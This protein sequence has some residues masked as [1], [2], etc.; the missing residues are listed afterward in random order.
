MSPRPK[1]LFAMSPEHLP[2][3][4]PEPLLDRLTGLVD[5]D[6]RLVGTSFSAEAGAAALAEAEILVTSW[7][8]PPL[9]EGILRGA[10]RL[11]SVVHAAGSVKHLVTAA[12][13]AKGLTFSS[14]A[15]A[16]AVP[17][18]EFTVGAILLAG[19]GVFS[20]HE[21]YLRTRTFTLGRVEPS[22]GNFGRRIGVVG[23][24]RIGARVLELLAPYDF[25]PALHDPYTTVPG[26]RH[27]S[28]DELLTTSDIVSLH[29]P[30]I[31]ETRHMIGA[32]ELAR[33]RDGA[34]WINTARGDLVDTRALAEELKTGRLAAVLDVTD[35]EPLAADSILFEL[36]NVF[37]TP[38]VAGSQGN[39]LARMGTVAVEEVERLT[40]GEAFAFGVDLDA[41]ARIA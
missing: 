32:P 12:A 34:V 28:L 15:G 24:S 6:P 13:R 21:R 3:L 35:P 17:V 11:R 25:E 40:R 18:A 10:P 22:V 37:L 19:K 9:D 36:P 20:L 29:A 16:N 30:S 4:F 41:L 2:L 31:P 8:C 23:A 26:V 14:A 1:A 5:I 38:H 33:R 27:L 39:E 7:G